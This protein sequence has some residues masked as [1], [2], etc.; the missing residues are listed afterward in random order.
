MG[1]PRLYEQDA[2]VASA[3]EVFWDRGYEGTALGD[4]EDATGLSRSSLYLAFGT[5]KGIFD[6]AVAEYVDTFIGS[7]LGPVEVPDAGLREAAGFFLGLAAFFRDRQSQRGC[8]MV[9]SIAELSGADPDWE[10]RGAQLV[11]RFR[12]A[13]SNALGQA[14]HQGAMSSRQATIRSEVLAASAMGIWLAVRGD[15]SAAAAT[16]RAIAT[17]IR[18]WGVS[19]TQART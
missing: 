13:F 2:V 9:N 15:H 12:A 4:L 1:R 7:H 11:D 8:L 6:A 16:C 5:K 3:K 19:S 14:V 10:A 18:S 17:E